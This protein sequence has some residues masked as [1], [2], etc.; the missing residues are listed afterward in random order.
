MKKL[1]YILAPALMILPMFFSCGGNTDPEKPKQKDSVLVYSFSKPEYV[2]GFTGQ[3]RYSYCPSVL[4]QS[5]DSKHIYFCGNPNPGIM[6]DNVYHFIEYSNGTRTAPTSVLQPSLSWDSHH[7]CDPCVIEGEFKM[8]AQTYK[9]AMFY[10]S[11]PVE[12]YYNEIGVAFSNDLNAA[13]WNKYPQQVVT[14]TWL[15]EGDQDL[16]GGNK[17]WGVGQPSAVSLDKKGKVLL[18]YTIGDASGTRVAFTT[19]DLSDMSKFERKTATNMNAAGLDN[20]NGNQDYT[21]NC[22]F[23]I[24]QTENKIVMVRPV[25]PH[26]STYPSYIPV[27]Q[28]VDYMDLN[29]FLAGIGKWTAIGRINVELSEYPRNHNACLM[30]DNFGHIEKWDTPTVYITVSKESPA[31]TPGATTHAEWTYHIYKTTVSKKWRYFD[32]QS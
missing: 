14:K 12:Y 5:D 10:L 7:T 26:P 6:V 24:N 3:N 23:A 11:N 9:Y 18:T 8:D 15:H 20:L 21:C 19:L 30:R 28:E 31:V 2:F 16:G 22:D 25:Q 4:R 1:L 32:K 13:S 17:S 27:A 29:N